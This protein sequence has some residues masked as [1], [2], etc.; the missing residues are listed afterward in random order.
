MRAARRAAPPAS[1]TTMVALSLSATTL[2]SSAAVVAVVVVVVLAAAAAAEVVV[3]SSRS[4]RSRGVGSDI[5]RLTPATHSPPPAA[6][7]AAERFAAESGEPPRTE[8][9]NIEQ[10]MRIRMLVQSGQARFRPARV[11]SRSTP[12]I[13]RLRAGREPRPPPRRSAP[14]PP[15]EPNSAGRR[16]SR[17]LSC[18]TT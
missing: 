14:V 6:Q 9:A 8:F 10:R 12:Y 13:E 17:P 15:A 2:L 16:S 7:D 3:V 1:P 5:A 18:S 4:S 11:P